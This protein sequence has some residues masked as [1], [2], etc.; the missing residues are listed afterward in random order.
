MADDVFLWLM[1]VM[2][3]DF[4]KDLGGTFIAVQ[5]SNPNKIEQEECTVQYLPYDF[6]RILLVY[7]SFRVL[8]RDRGFHLKIPIWVWINTY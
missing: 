3:G 2:N 4:A 5:Y 7:L 6:S 8:F 1:M